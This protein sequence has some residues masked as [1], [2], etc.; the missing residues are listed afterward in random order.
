[1]GISNGVRR[2]VIFLFVIQII[3]WEATMMVVVMKTKIILLNSKI[4]EV[5]GQRIKGVKKRRV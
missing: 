1:M 5:L 3:S 4:S 2:R